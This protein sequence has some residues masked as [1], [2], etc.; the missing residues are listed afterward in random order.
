[1]VA[2]KKYFYLYYAI[3]PLLTIGISLGFTTFPIAFFSLLPL[4]VLT[5]RH[6]VGLFFVM[7]GGTLGGVTRAMFPFLPV[8]GILLEL[9]GV[10]LMWDLIL[11]LI[12]IRNRAFGLIFITLAFFAIF[13]FLGPMDGFAKNKYLSMCIHGIFMVIGYYAFAQSK[14]VD[15]KGLMG[16]LILMAICFY[17]Y[18]ITKGSFVRGGLL[19]FNWF[20]SQCE[21]YD[22]INN[23]E[24]DLLIGYQQIG[25][26]ALFG[27]A[28]YLS[29]TQ[30]KLWESAYFVGCASLLVLISGARQAIL[31]LVL[32]I[33]F[34][35]VVFKMS[36]VNRNII[37]RLLW[38]TIGLI[39]VFIVLLFALQNSGSDVVTNTLTSGDAGRMGL[40][41]AAIDMYQNNPLMGCGIG[42]YHALTGEA[43]PHNLF[44]ELMCE[45]GLIGLII[46]IMLIVIP[47]RLNK[48][49]LLHIT[50][51][52]QF[53]F[54]ILLASFVRVM[55]SVDLRVSI[56]LFSAVY[57]ITAVKSTNVKSKHRSQLLK[58]T[59]K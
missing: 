44:L 14:N 5:N 31:G 49:G 17:S 54:L 48:Q 22:Y 50:M 20:R 25:M 34:R 35:F 55:V 58:R 30:L 27:I 28:V 59:G 57:A 37:G 56:E 46:S 7:Y 39:S 38:I 26:S 33:A 4:L 41:M 18:V 15:A 40:Y 52:N 43:W 32:I 1:M 29:Q 16:I 8:Y 45:T 24:S 42:S 10:L 47:L 51:S 13:Y 2:I 19:D 3:I 9:L 36:N 6:T 11:N 21:W 12:R 53:V 23:Y